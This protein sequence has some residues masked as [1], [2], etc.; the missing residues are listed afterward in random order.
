[1]KIFS[2]T[3]LLFVFS[4]TAS[5]QYKIKKVYH[6]EWYVSANTG[7]NYL[8]AE[9]FNEYLK[10]SPTKAIGFLSHTSIGYNFT[11]IWGVRGDIGFSTHTWPEN[12]KN[13]NIATNIMAENM[14]AN[15]TANMI[16]WLSGYD[17]NRMYD[18]SLFGG[19]GVSYRNKGVFNNALISYIGRV[20]AQ[21]D[22]RITR[23]LSLNLLAEVN[24]VDDNYNEYIG[25][26]LPFDFY[27][28]LS[29]GF[30][31]RFP[32]TDIFLQTVKVN[33]GK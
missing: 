11:A 27:P 2:I 8:M 14:T 23:E 24:L 18:V 15:V 13:N 6:P 28:A 31:Y 20:G 25:T 9:G 30:S 12:S 5:A 4:F 29:I 17:S 22:Y 26:K 7:I 3:I 21:A 33:Y 19:L 16:N 32:T 1:M 10:T